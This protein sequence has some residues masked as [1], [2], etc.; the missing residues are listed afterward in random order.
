MP[1]GNGTGPAGLGP[2]TGRAAGYCAGYNTPGYAN[3]GGGGFGRGLGRGRG[4]G[5][6]RGYGRGYGFR[7]AAYVPQAPYYGQPYQASYGP[8]PTAK[9]EAQYLKEEA[10]GLKGELEAINQRI[11]DLES[12]E[13][14]K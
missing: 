8:A 3:P 7:G 13:K 2:M 10:Q 6:G 12:Q 4:R 1:A 5:F 14:K 11:K 9:E